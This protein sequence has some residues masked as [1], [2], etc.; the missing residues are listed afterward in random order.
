M[1]RFLYMT[2]PHAMGRSPETRVD[3]YSSTIERKIK[4]FFEMGHDLKVDFFGCGG[5]WVNSA[6]TSQRYAKRLGKLIKD[7][8]RDKEIFHIW[9]NHDVIGWNPTTIQDT[10]FGLAEEFLDNMTLLSRTPT[11][12]EYKGRKI[13]LTGVSSYA[14]LDRDIVKDEV[15]VESRSRDYIVKDNQNL[16]WIH[17]VH[18][19]LSPKPIL[20]GIPHTVIEEMRGT[21]ATITLTGHEHGGFPVTQIDNGLVYN[22]GALGRVFASHV[23]MNRMPKYAL[24]T[25]HDDGTPRIE[26]IQCPVAEV[27]SLVM[28]RTALDEKKAREELLVQA[29][30][31]MQEVLRT[32]NIQGIDLR[33]IIHRFKDDVK[34]DVYNEV[35][36]R[37]QL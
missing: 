24:C 3:D 21:K 19:Y 5:D 1:I 27:G 8:S 37:L 11:Y 4:N 22:P 35:T 23:E 7:S 30:G 6:Y 10:S 9:G 12:R 13:A 2:D 33:T 26:P 32:I 25:I 36:R 29:K 17:M 14:Q 15:V 28:D 34:P 31:N 18:G 16:P 20:D